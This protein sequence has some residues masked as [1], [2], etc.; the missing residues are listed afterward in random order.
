MWVELCFFASVTCLQGY[1][2]RHLFVLR[3]QSLDMNP[4]SLCQHN[5]MLLPA[6]KKKKKNWSCQNIY[7]KNITTLGHVIIICALCKLIT[8][9]LRDTNTLQ[10]F[11]I[12]I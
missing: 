1:I 10:S 2:R 11:T 8:D 3:A 9:E 7:V 12:S 5:K 6:K 4:L